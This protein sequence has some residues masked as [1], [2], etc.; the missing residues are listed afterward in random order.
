MTS[1]N[2]GTGSY[3]QV[4]GVENHLQSVAR[5]GTGTTTFG[6]D[7]GGQ[8]V[9]T[10]KPNGDIVYT[11]FP[12]VEEELRGAVSIK[13]RTSQERRCGQDKRSTPPMTSSP[14]ATCQPSRR[15]PRVR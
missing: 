8:R 1:R 7:A 10:T 11:P 4:F 13:R 14:P 15:S 3:T 2:D 9:R 12:Q 5:S 6:Y